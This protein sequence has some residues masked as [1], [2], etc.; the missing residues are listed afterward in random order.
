MAFQLVQNL[1]DNVNEYFNYKPYSTNTNY[2]VILHVGEEQDYKKFYAHSATLKVKSKY[3]ESALSSR[4]INKEDNY[5]I[6]RIPNISPKVFEI[7]LR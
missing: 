4:W 2:D 7:I 5:Y 1:F 3:F 6:L